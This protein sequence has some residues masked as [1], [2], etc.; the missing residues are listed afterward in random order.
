MRL[1]NIWRS[2]STFKQRFNPPTV[3]KKKLNTPGDEEI[4]IW[5][6]LTVAEKKLNTPENEEIFCLN[7]KK[8]HPEV[9]D[10]G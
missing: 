8:K 2:L 1:R 3:A 10:C 4:K 9:T 6:S 7:K 5:R